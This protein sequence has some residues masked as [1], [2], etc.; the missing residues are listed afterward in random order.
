MQSISHERPVE[1][2][3]EV[4]R[5][6]R[7]VCEEHAVPGAARLMASDTEALAVRLQDAAVHGW[8]EA[9][10]LDSAQ[11]LRA[12]QAENSRLWKYVTAV[13]VR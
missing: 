4:S 3:S 13:E 1:G 9:L 10:M 6:E 5:V 12:L 11:R 8:Y 7:G 2:D